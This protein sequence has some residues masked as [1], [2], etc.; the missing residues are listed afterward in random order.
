MR[1]AE[2]IGTVTL[3]CCLP[4]FDGASLRVV[5]PLGLSALQGEDA[6]DAEPVIVF[7]ELAAGHRSRI[8]LS[9]GAEA[10]QPFRPE[11]KPVD[12]YN[13]AIIEQLDI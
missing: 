13:A 9:E 11:L 5:L 2:V 3:S 8:A 10:A 6:S 1:I 7:D 4:E 12:A